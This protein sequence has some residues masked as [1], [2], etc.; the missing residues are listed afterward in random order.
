MM[1]EQFEIDTNE[2]KK[3]EKTV[4]KNDDDWFDDLMSNDVVQ[5]EEKKELTIDKLFGKITGEQCHEE[6]LKDMALIT[7]QHLMHKFIA[8]C[9]K[10]DSRIDQNTFIE[11][12]MIPFLSLFNYDKNKVIISFLETCKLVDCISL[13]CTSKCL[14]ENVAVEKYEI[15]EMQ[16]YP[17]VSSFIEQGFTMKSQNVKEMK[18][19]PI[20]RFR[21]SLRFEKDANNQLSIATKKPLPRPPVKLT[22]RS[23]AYYDS[24]QINNNSNGADSKAIGAQLS[25]CLGMNLIKEIEEP[26]YSYLISRV[27]PPVHSLNAITHLYKESRKIF[28]EHMQEKT[29]D[30][31][32]TSLYIMIIFVVSARTKN[33]S[34]INKIIQEHDEDKIF[35]LLKDGIDVIDETREEMSDEE[36][37]TTGVLMIMI[38]P[39]LGDVLNSIAMS[40]DIII[41]KWK[42][43]LI[44]YVS[45]LTPISIIEKAPCEF[46]FRL[47]S[48]RCVEFVEN[49]I[50]D[51]KDMN[52]IYQYIQ[53]NRADIVRNTTYSIFQSTSVPS[54]VKQVEPF[55]IIPA[56]NNS[57]VVENTPIHSFCCS[58]DNNYVIYS[59][60]NKIKRLVKMEGS[61]N[62]ICYNYFG[63]HPSTKK[64]TR[65]SNITALC[66][67]P[68][69]K[70]PYF[71]AGTEDG[72]ILVFKYTQDEAIQMVTIHNNV[73]VSLNQSMINRSYAIKSVKWNSSGTKFIVSD[74]QGYI[75]VYSFN[76]NEVSLIYS[77][78]L[79]DT[80]ISADFINDSIFFYAV[81]NIG[82]TTGS[83][84]IGNSLQ[85]DSILTATYTNKIVTCTFAKE[86]GYVIIV[87]PDAIK[88]IDI[89]SASIVKTIELP[90]NQIRAIALDFYNIEMFIGLSD[91]T[92]QML[93]FPD[94]TNKTEVGK[95]QNKQ[96]SVSFLK[97]IISN[98][99]INKLEVLWL[100]K[101]AQPELYSCS[102][103]GSIIQ[104][105]VI[106]YQ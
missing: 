25:N 105:S 4:T 31:K 27:F 53:N 78:K 97:S 93:H 32:F 64:A 49:E 42:E 52:E 96:K 88:Y 20:N 54:T 5:V 92:L 75:A 6:D 106:Y 33:Y 19:N 67:D 36:Q 29:L 43:S 3:T 57:F 65:V 15:N 7:S 80:S 2:N 99:S 45:Y 39:L 28:A 70:Y 91:G 46:S 68:N 62:D 11:K 76:I 73:G 47:F 22:P 77:H 104:R 87:E 24:M 58:A 86:Y 79:F 69:P 85:S 30:N 55:L 98:S 37:F 90:N 95:H 8:L 16:S 10:P 23:A 38:L 21:E 84:I 89:N 35:E 74:V 82:N 100:D 14:N 72:L 59:I 102:N 1:K 50:K 83:V 81:G 71:L 61:S 13:L 17:F 56:S 44:N 51:D 34:L 48:A 41:G 101:N 9:K 103:D 94:V 66:L 40:E 63:M 26:L 60:K 18:I 12:R